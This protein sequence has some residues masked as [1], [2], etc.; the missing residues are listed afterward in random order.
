MDLDFLEVRSVLLV[1]V[2]PLHLVHQLVQVN[3]CLLVI[4]S[5]LLVLA[6]PVDLAVL[7]DS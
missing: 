1:L 5:V 4:L 7:R 6:Y 2:V 3:L